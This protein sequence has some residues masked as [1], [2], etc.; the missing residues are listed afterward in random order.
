M[1]GSLFAPYKAAWAIAIHPFVTAKNE[2]YVVMMVTC[3][4]KKNAHAVPLASAPAS[5]RGRYRFCLAER[6]K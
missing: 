5:H 3:A 4:I 2:N 1:P 6:E